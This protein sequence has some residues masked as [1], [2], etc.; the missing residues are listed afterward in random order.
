MQFI[1]FLHLRFVKFNQNQF[2]HIV[3]LINNVYLNT[4]NSYSNKFGTHNCSYTLS[5]LCR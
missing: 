3:G 1:N 2:S 5:K 4:K